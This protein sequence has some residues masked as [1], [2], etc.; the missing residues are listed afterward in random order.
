MV[1]LAIRS[2][3]SFPVP[4]MDDALRIKARSVGIFP[5]LLLEESPSGLDFPAE[6][7]AFF[8]TDAFARIF[9]GFVY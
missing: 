4:L 6:A 1:I 8:E 3:T 2:S 5:L 7:T 9:S